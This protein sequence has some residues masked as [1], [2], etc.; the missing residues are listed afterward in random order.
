MSARQRQLADLERYVRR[1]A[2]RRVTMPRI[3]RLAGLPTLA[4][5]A[6][7]RGAP[8]LHLA[9]ARAIGDLFRGPPA[10]RSRRDRP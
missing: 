1:L 7:L 4:V 2:A 5:E 3:A 10:Y 8:W 6:I 9:A